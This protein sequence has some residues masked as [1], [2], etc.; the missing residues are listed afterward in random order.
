M[1]HVL[2]STLFLLSGIL[3]A[4]NKADSTLNKWE[5]SLLVSANVSQVAFENWSKGGEN[6]LSYAFGLDWIMKYKSDSKW[7]FKNQLKGDWG[8]TQ[9]N[10][11]EARVTSNNIYN[12]SVFLVDVGWTVE[13]YASNLIRTP[14]TDGYNYDALPKEQIVAFFDP[15]YVTQS[16]GF[17]YQKSE[18]IQTR[19]GLAFEE[20]FA[21][22]FAVK[23][24]DD[25]E[26]PNEIED[27]KYETGIESITDVK[28]EV[29]E[30]VLYTGK[31]RLFSAFDRFTVWDV[32]MDNTFTA[33]VNDWLHVKF[34]YYLIYK[35]SETLKTQTQEALQVGVSYN[36]F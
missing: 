1:K 12:E 32:A 18:I 35:A 19:L 15:G 9:N 34:S 29:A 16:L 10:G 4:Q 31:L 23:Y 6:S 28:W 36:I 5:P 17:A 13:P 30:N 26:T 27:F 20:S 11:D 25:P 24:T 22:K 21:S 14:I 2:L 33:K 3:F 7:T 8:K